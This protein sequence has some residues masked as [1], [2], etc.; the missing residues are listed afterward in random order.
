MDGLKKAGVSEAQHPSTFANKMIRATFRD[1]KHDDDMMRLFIAS[2]DGLKTVGGWRGGECPICTQNG[3]HDP[4][5]L[6][7]V[8]VHIS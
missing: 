3:P 1:C 5:L 6:Q 2:M 4:P 8:E 7:T